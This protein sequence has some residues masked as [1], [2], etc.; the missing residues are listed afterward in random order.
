MSDCTL[1]KWNRQSKKVYVDC[2]L[3][4]RIGVLAM[5]AL[6]S[7]VWLDFATGEWTW[8]LAFDSHLVTNGDQGMN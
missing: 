1:Q 7:S 6:R 2:N 5:L 8:W 3:C 4:G